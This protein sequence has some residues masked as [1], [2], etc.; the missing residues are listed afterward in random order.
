MKNEKDEEEEETEEAKSINENKDE[1]MALAKTI[2]ET[3]VNVKHRA[4]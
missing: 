2:N 3:D 1:N 4:N